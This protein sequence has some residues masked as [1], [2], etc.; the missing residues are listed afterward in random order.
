[1]TIYHLLTGWH[2]VL[3]IPRPDNK[4]Q[5]IDCILND[6]SDIEKIK[7]YDWSNPVSVEYLFKLAETYPNKIIECGKIRLFEK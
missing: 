3:L 6:L 5:V 2:S 7:Y 1:M 4:V